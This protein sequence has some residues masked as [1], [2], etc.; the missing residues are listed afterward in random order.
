MRGFVANTDWDWFRFLR[1]RP[2]LDE[3]NFWQPGGQ[4]NFRALNPGEP[5]LFR[6]TSGR[7]AIAG[8]G[9]FAAF[10][11][12]PISIAWDSFGEKNGVATFEEFRSRIM[13][14]RKSD[15][16]ATQD[17]EIGCIVLVQPFFLEEASWIDAPRDFVPG[18]QVGKRYDLTVSP[19]KELWD[20]LRH[21][22]LS[23]GQPMIGEGRDD[24][25]QPEVIFGE[26]F[27]RR[28]YGQ[29]AFRIVITDS[30]DR[31]C[32]VTGER[33]LPVL[34]AAHVKPITRGGSHEPKNGLLL[35]SDVH[36]LFDLGY[37][38][39]NPNYQFVVSDD[40][41]RNWNNGRVYYDFD[42]RSIFLP[43]DKRNRVSPELLE[44]HYDEVFRK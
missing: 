16:D 8:G 12:V 23:P 41:R 5:L 21:A 2:Y 40:L 7:N 17:F 14:H 35:R 20:R 6:L 38:G 27:V 34:D 37:V 3:V 36:T 42:K 29:G 30:Y 11:R 18:I 13:Q 32:A 15:V 4:R 9:F 28:R 31:R 33:T 19:G 44:W 10:S 39:I 26:A 1:N 25:L 43:S 24:V 22:A